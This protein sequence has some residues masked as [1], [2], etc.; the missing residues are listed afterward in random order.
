MI[1]LILLVVALT[2]ASTKVLVIGVGEYNDTSVIQ[3][4]GALKD[5]KAFSEI[6]G[7]T[8]DNPSVE[9]IENPTLTSLKVNILEWARKSEPGDTLILYYSGHGYSIDNDTYLIPSDVNTRYIEDTAYNFTT[10][11]K[12][13]SSDISANDVLIIIDACYSGSLVSDER[14]LTDAK[15]KEGTIEEIAKERGYVFLLSSKSNETSKER[16][17]GGGQFTY[18]LLK[19]IEGEANRDNDE[20]ITVNEVYDY[21]KEEVR[22]ETSNNQTPVMVGDRDIVIAKDMRS[23]Y[24]SLTL[25]IARMARDGRIDTEYIGLYTKILFQKESDD[26]ELDK[27]VRKYLLTYLSDNNLTSLIAQTTVAI[28][29]SSETP[30]NNQQQTQSQSTT[31]SQAKGNCLLK[32]I[33]GN[34]LTKSGIVYLNGKEEGTL[35]DGQ[36][37]IF[38][39][40]IGI[41]TLAIDGEKIDRQETAIEFESD[42]ETKEIMIE[43]KPATRVLRIVTIPSNAKIWIDGRELS[44]RSPWQE[45]LE[46][47]KAYEIEVYVEGYGR[48]KRIANIP[49]KGD[50]ITFTITIPPYPSPEKP[51]LTYPENNSRDIP[52]GNITLKWES[53]ESDFTYR[54]EFDSKTYTT[55]N[56]SYTVNATERGKTYTWKVTSV[57]EFGKETTSETYSF[58]TMDNRAPSTPSNTSPSNNATNQPTTITLSWDCSDEDGDSLTYDVYFDT[59]TN[60]TTKI[61]TSQNGRTL[62]RSN[63][64]IGTNYY[65]RIVA[66]DSKGATTEGPVWRFTTQ[67]NKSPNTPS[68]PSPS[69]N[70][71][72]QPL[73]VKLSWD[74]SDP[75]GDAV[76]YDV[77]FGTNSNPPKVS[78]NQSGKSLDKT[79]LS[80][81]TTYYWRIVAKDSN[82]ATTEG[83][84]W[85]FTTQT[86]PTASSYTPSSI[87]PQ[88]VLVEKGSFSMGD[89]VGELWE[90]CRPIHK[91]TLTYSFYIGKYETTFD[92][93]DAFCEATGKSSPDDE[94]WGRGDRPVINVSWWDAIA[95]CN[96][97]S[98]KE[99][100]P[101]AYDSNGN[102]L[103]KYGRI[104]TDIT[105]VFGYRLPTEVEWEYAARGGNRSKGYKYSGGNNVANVALY[106]QNSGDQYLTGDR[107]WDRIVENNCCTQEVGSKTANEL[108]IYDMSGN[109]WE[110]CSD[111]YGNYS[112]SEKT[113][114]YNDS[115][116][117][118]VYRGGSWYSLAIYIRVANRFYDSPAGAYPDLGFRIAR[119]VP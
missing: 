69:S 7:R 38:D 104:S 53:K 26:N 37:T 78:T 48:D 43:G 98:E 92:E 115:G 62:N 85:R 19:G 42:Y 82:G 114:P 94:N 44:S 73:T 17:E 74:C 116:S 88:T 90:G 59:K 83:P 108:G 86:V 105:Q 51:V 66:K 113:N 10:G 117:D 41:Y 4:P 101:E 15:I 118:R 36:L 70:L 110:W 75:D 46:V 40:G 33:A 2:L 96:W 18:Y 99:K 32:I 84:V 29:Q 47:G 67:S 8:A 20:E 27:K 91:V 111:W 57:N 93:Y 39:L 64:S 79:N 76:T 102:L 109:V 34:E 107:D 61:S 89:E 56:T 31:Q 103:D 30:E 3:L 58:R 50:L 13:I 81:E 68:N 54:V 55:N 100:L 63:L 22:K 112:S 87:V 71:T 5:A 25:E 11:L 80:Y 28:M 119:T 106:W 12:S 49:T 1:T 23:V 95:Y 21:L 35:Q 6:I 24:D 16:E 72:N 60:P 77:H 9:L 45:S 14:P 65:W 97:L 52:T